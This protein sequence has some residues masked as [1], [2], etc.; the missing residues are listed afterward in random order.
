MTMRN[1]R[2]KANIKVKDLAASLEIA[3]STVWN[4]EQGRTIPRLRADQFFK[5][6]RL[7][8]CTVEE[9]EQAVEETSKVKQ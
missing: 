3:E 4:W 5:L 7:Y 6:L 1:L 8:K 2:K 9:L